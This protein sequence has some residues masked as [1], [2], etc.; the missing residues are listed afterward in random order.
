MYREL[1]IWLSVSSSCD[2]SK[3]LI[4][5][6]TG[7]CSLELSGASVFCTRRNRTCASARFKVSHGLLRVPAHASLPSR[8]G[9]QVDPFERAQTLKP[10]YHFIGFKG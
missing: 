4:Q 9:T 10:G 3:F 8:S 6:C 1:S 5:I 2:G 7:S